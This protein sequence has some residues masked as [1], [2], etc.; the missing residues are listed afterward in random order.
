MSVHLTPTEEQR[1]VLERLEVPA[2]IAA[3]LRRPSFTLSAGDAEAV[4]DA[5]TEALAQVGFGADYELTADGHLIE[6]LI[7]KLFVR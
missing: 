4:R 7:D 5:L 2:Q 1:R 3:L 6:D